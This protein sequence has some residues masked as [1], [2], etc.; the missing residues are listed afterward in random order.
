M[1][2]STAGRVLQAW[3]GNSL[4]F[5]QT[6]MGTEL[7]IYWGVLESGAVVPGAGAL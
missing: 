5:L 6:S 4:L 7:E 1:L 3:R 2:Q